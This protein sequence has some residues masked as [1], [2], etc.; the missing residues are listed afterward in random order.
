M[1]C[2][3]CKNSFNP[4]ND[5]RTGDYKNCCQNCYDSGD[6]QICANCNGPEHVEL[7][8]DY[9]G[10]VLCKGCENIAVDQGWG[11]SA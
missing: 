8:T 3:F 4:E 1:E 5:G 6:I 7:T 9:N 2:N 10:Q 11:K